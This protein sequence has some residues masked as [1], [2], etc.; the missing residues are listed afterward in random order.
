[1]ITGQR[2]LGGQPFG[3]ADHQAR[4]AHLPRRQDVAEVAGA[5]VLEQ[6]AVGAP[7]QVDAA[8]GLHGAAGDEL[9]G[10]SSGHAD[11]R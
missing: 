9:E 5:A 8:P 4:L 10:L 11:A 7:F 1:M 6:V 2:A 3:R